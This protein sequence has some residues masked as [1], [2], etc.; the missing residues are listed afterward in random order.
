MIIF[1]KDNIIDTKGFTNIRFHLY[2]DNEY[3]ITCQT[4]ILSLIWQGKDK[5]KGKEIFNKIKIVV[6]NELEFLV[7]EE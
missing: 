2:N 4:S 3:A 5:E 6:V 1:T 7:I